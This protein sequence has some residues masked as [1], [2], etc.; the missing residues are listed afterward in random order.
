MFRLRFRYRSILAQHDRER[1][2]YGSRR[3]G[4]RSA[5]VSLGIG[6]IRFL[7]ARGI[8]TWDL[9]R[10]ESFVDSKSCQLEILSIGRN[11]AMWVKSGKRLGK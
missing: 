7:T 4:G 6:S 3:F 5:A 9:F 1:V 8:V 11:Y 2:T 10:L